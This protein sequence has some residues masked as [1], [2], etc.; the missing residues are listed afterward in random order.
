MTTKAQHTPGPCQHERVND[1]GGAH[2]ICATCE[3]RISKLTAALSEARAAL[4]DI[5]ESYVPTTG[6]PVGHVHQDYID[7]ARALLARIEGG[8]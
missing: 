4:T 1:F 2:V 6:H 8:K 3:A 7:S 5:V